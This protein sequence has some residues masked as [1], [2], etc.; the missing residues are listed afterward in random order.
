MGLTFWEPLAALL[1]VQLPLAVQVGDVPVVDHVNVDEPPLVML[2]G[3]AVSVTVGG[4]TLLTVTVTDL[5]SLPAVFEQAK[6]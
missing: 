4:V 6:V 3:D 2:V 5:L 1:P